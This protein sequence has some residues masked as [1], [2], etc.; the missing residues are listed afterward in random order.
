MPT[1]T[2]L[3]VPIRI[4]CLAPPDPERYNAAFGLQERT[5]D[6]N[7]KIH[8]GTPVAQGD[9]L[10]SCTVSIRGH[11][12][13]APPDFFGSFVHGKPGGRFLYLS[14]RPRGWHPSVA[15][16]PAPS[17]VRR[18]KISLQSIPWSLVDQ[19]A[20]GEVALLARVQGTAPDG[21]PNCASVTLL[22]EGWEIQPLHS[23]APPPP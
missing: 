7:W 11:T 12:R 2:P 15:E 6:S 14:W 16:P 10:F 4:V 21:G 13:T 5:K 17:W 23:A 19:A 18:M 3:A 20:T 9:F 22:G 8:A 1:P